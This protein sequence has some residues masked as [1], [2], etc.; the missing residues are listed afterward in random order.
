MLST[1]A[2]RPSM[3]L[4]T[5]F[6][7][8]ICRLWPGESVDVLTVDPPEPQSQIRRDLCDPPAGRPRVGWRRERRRKPSHTLR[9]S[10]PTKPFRE[11]TSASWMTSRSKLHT[12]THYTPTCYCHIISAPLR[13]ALMIHIFWWATACNQITPW[14]KS[15]CCSGSD[16]E[17]EDTSQGSAPSSPGGASEG[18]PQHEHQVCGCSP[19]LPGPEDAGRDVSSQLEPLYCHRLV[20]FK[21]EEIISFSLSE[22]L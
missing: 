19:L 12:H 16:S 7:W 17:P 2:F 21:P 14:L 6:G 22:F 10:G 18:H 9:L 15:S 13:F 11:K 8:E 5:K 1:L 3:H 4:Q 20:G